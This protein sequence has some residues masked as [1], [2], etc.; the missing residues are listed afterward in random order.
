[1]ELIFTGPEPMPRTFAFARM[2]SGAGVANS[3]AC[4]PSG[5]TQL[6]QLMQQC[7]NPSLRYRTILIRRHM[8]ADAPHPLALLRPR[9]ERP[10]RR[11]AEQRD[12]LATFHSITSSA[13]ASSVCGTSRPSAFAALRLIAN[14]NLVGCTT[15]RS[16]GRAPLSTLPT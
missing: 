14:S 15:G 8:H 5:P 10:S 7:R 4:L 11:A 3:A 2:T 16:A 13:V 12:E 6:P 1:R 9:R